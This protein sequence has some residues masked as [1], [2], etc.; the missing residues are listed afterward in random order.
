M[1]FLRRH[2]G[3]LNL[4]NLSVQDGVPKDAVILEYSAHIW[5]RGPYGPASETRG[6]YGP[7]SDVHSAHV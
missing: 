2:C 6:P 5:T 3:A 7:A 4:L 1:K